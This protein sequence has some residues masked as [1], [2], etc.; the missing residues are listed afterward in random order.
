[1]LVLASWFF[2]L[3]CAGLHAY[4]C[5]NG[6]CAAQTSLV[7]T[8]N[9]IHV[10]FHDELKHS[11]YAGSLPV[12][13]IPA[14]LIEGNQLLSCVFIYALSLQNARAGLNCIVPIHNHR[15]RSSSFC[16]HAALWQMA[17]AAAPQWR[18]GKRR[19]QKGLK[20]TNVDS[21]RTHSSFSL[22]TLHLII[23]LYLCESY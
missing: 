15:F 11:C 18:K 21:V 23:G 19:G 8:S 14:S 6:E 1:M 20:R 13:I 7:S 9:S 12:W 2:R 10:N 5:L 17:S 3:L 16:V 4:T 22:R